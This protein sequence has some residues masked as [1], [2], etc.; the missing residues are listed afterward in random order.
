MNPNDKNEPDSMRVDG[1]AI[2]PESLSRFIGQAR[3]VANIRLAIAAAIV[4]H[5]PLDHTLLAGPPGLGKT[6]MAR[7]IASEMG[8]RNFISIVAPSLEHP[9]HLAGILSAM[10]PGTVLFIDE[11]H[12]LAREMEEYMYSAM[13]DRRITIT[14]GEGMQSQ[15][16]T[17]PL[18]PFTLIGATTREGMLSAPFL[19]RF[20]IRE[21]MELYGDDDLV[22][23]LTGCLP[24]LGITATDDSLI[25]IAAISRGTPRIAQSY[26]RRLRDFAQIE[27]YGHLDLPLTRRGLDA[28]GVDTHGLTSMD[29]RIISLLAASHRPV[30]LKTIAVAIGEDERTIE[31]VH[32]P[33]LVQQGIILRTASGRA[34]GRRGRELAGLTVTPPVELPSW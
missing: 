29:H 16:I 27:Q 11:I 23:I 15:V 2:R 9:G 3:V 30:G 31:D 18:A 33:Y 17:M 20:G 19:S 25:A 21:R 1:I 8:S 13:E 12:A 4:R 22:T 7:I 5:E 6:T 32:E 24:H 26:L 10:T 34:L 28:L 14:A